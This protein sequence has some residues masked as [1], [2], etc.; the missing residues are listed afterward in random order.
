MDPY[1]E[2]EERSRKLAAAITSA[3]ACGKRVRLSRGTSNLFRRR[4]DCG[5]TRL[6]IRGFVHL[7]GIHPGRAVADVEGMIPYDTFAAATLA[8]SFVPA[9]V[10]QLKSITV[11]GAVSG[12]GIESS[13]FR[14]GLAH[15][16]VEEMSIL[17]GD[18][19]RILCSPNNHQDLFFGFPNS[20]GTLGYVLR[21]AVR[22]I[23][24]KPF[25][26]LIHSRF[27]DPSRYF[28]RIERIC[29]CGGPDYLDGTVFGPT[30][31]YLT[32]GHF[33]EEAP[34]TSDYTWMRIYYRSIREKSEDWMTLRDYLWRWDTDWFWCSKN[35][36][37]QIPVVR[38]L[39]TRRLLNS[40]T[41]QRLMRISQRLLPEKSGS[42]SVIQDV[43]IPV[44]RA[45]EFLEFLF[46][47][48]GIQP[49]WICP[50]HAPTPGR[51]FPLYALDP[52]KT[53]VNFGFWDVLSTPHPPG[54][55]NRKVERKLVELGGKK[56]LYS[57]VFFDEETFDRL[58][59]RDVYR[60]LKLKYDPEG[61]LG[62]LFEKCTGRS[63]VKGT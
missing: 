28:E 2:H 26:R 46:S 32:E 33:S 45:A 34:G 16:T 38:L 17:L 12:V 43:D 5:E 49:I 57:S 10:P 21:L 3:C 54:Y 29:A 1:A 4:K 19:R 59:D 56:G 6:D 47:E 18:G 55:F 63:R 53:Y 40:R 51:R 27:S 48:I 8:R 23:P 36:F 15:D 50:I 14:F 62:D 61:L 13:S 42:E 20:Y 60:Q 39:M 9:V 25:V 24:A 22:L 52:A 41:Y 37:A 31:M 44:H 30:E 58:Y 7:L 35:F 11:G